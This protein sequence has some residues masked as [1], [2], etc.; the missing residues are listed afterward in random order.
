MAN[1]KTVQ[2]SSELYNQLEAKRQELSKKLGVRLSLA[3]TIQY[4]L[5]KGA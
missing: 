5:N 2:L 3:K 4:L 1:F